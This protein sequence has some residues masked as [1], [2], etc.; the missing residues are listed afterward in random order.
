MAAT[1]AGQGRMA[2]AAA[3]AGA[4]VIFLR[5]VTLKI[6]YQKYRLFP[7]ILN[8]IGL[9]IIC[10]QGLYLIQHKL[11]YVQNTLSKH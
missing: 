6:P 2:V 10:I 11:N 9:N 4:A 3:A 7:Q 1:A 5:P 8:F